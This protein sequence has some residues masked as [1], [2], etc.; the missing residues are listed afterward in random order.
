MNP[1]RL[2]ID[3]LVLDGVDPRDARAVSEAVQAE[4]TRLLTEAPPTRSAELGR[5]VAQVP[6]A[7]GAALGASVAGAVHARLPRGGQS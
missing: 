4:L 2:H 5:G 7:R 6:H 3:R 1:V